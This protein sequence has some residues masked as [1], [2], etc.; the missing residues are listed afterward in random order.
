[1]GYNKVLR[2]I[3]IAYEA[4]NEARTLAD[5]FKFTNEERKTITFEE[6]IKVYE[7]D[8]KFKYSYN[9]IY[10][11]E[12]IVNYFNYLGEAV[13]KSILSSV[14]CK[15]DL[16]YQEMLFLIIFNKFKHCTLDY[17]ILN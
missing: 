13:I 16:T 8:F 1:M 14:N 6:A 17:L 4:K 7:D 2:N 11:K 9:S 5:L 10:N 12:E 15:C 3:N